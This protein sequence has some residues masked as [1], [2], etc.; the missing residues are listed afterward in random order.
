MHNQAWATIEGKTG[1]SGYTKSPKGAAYH[2]IFD[3]FNQHPPCSCPSQVVALGSCNLTIAG[4][5]FFPSADDVPNKH[6]VVQITAT[7][8]A[9]NVQG[10]YCCSENNAT[11]LQE[12]AKLAIANLAQKESLAKCFF[13]APAIET[14]VMAI[15]KRV[16]DAVDL[17][18]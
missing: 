18:P 1:Y 4:C 14:A 5:W 13:S 17:L 8:M 7:D 3:L 15:K 12:G 6:V 16:D 11:A 9:T 2:A 10:T